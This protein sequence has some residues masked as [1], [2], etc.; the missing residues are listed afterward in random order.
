[1]RLGI[2]LLEGHE[3]ELARLAEAHGLFGVLAGSGNPATSV[4]AA[5]YA[6][7]ATEFVRIAV[8][9]RLGLEHPITLAEELSILDNVNNGRTLVIADTG[10]LD[11][12]SAADEVA[13]LA[14]LRI[15]QAARG[16][17]GVDHPGTHDVD[18][19]PER[20]PVKR[21]RLAQHHHAALGG[22]VG[23]RSWVADHRVD[24][25]DHHDCPSA[26]TADHGVRRRPRREPGA[27]EV[28]GD[29]A[30]EVLLGELV[31]RTVFL[32]ACAGDQAVH[33]S[34]ALHRLA[35]HCIARRS[36]ADV[37]PHG[38]RG[39]QGLGRA[40]SR[41]HDQVAADDLVTTCR[42]GSRGRSPDPRSRSRDDRD[43]HAASPLN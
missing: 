35:D 41:F 30:V 36:A 27:L 22:A 14:P 43:G 42:Q 32:H 16:H 21:E 5:V 24:G 2:V 31:S 15:G 11:A 38:D 33:L 26:T 9:S 23:A 39:F 6:S 10:E 18:P 17:R 8:R 7:T 4:N 37:D 1:M 40:L 3:G 34:E 29:D 28:D 12:E 20:R 25:S 19:D 13:V